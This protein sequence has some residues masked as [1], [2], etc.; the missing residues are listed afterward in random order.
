MAEFNLDEIKFKMRKRF[1]FRF[2]K[3][4]GL[5]HSYYKYIHSRKTYNGFQKRYANWTW[6]MCASCYGVKSM[7]SM[8]IAWD[9]TDEGYEYW[10]DKHDKFQQKLNKW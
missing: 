1:F 7:I 3:E 9:K 6:D 8:L 4:N 5:Y 2:L 10:A